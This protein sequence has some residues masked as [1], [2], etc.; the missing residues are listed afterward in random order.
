MT[1][2]LLSFVVWALAAGSAVFWGNRFLAQP[3]PVPAQAGA[4]VGPTAMVAGPMTRLFG[5]APVVEVAAPPPALADA[6]FK[7]L[8]VAAP[9]AGQHYGWALIAVDDRPARSFALGARVDEGLVVQTISHRQVELGARDAKPSVTLALA[10]V[11]EAARGMPAPAIGVPTP[12][13]TPVGAAVRPGRMGPTG[14]P[15][16]APHP[17]TLPQP[18]FGGAMPAQQP[19]MPAAPVPMPPPTPGNEQGAPLQTR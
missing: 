7:L 12:G 5:A 8:G 18:P 16:Q 17:G 13:V 9:R 6:R 3:V 11:A 1:A 10:P 14:Q 2:R 4:A 19:V 15:M